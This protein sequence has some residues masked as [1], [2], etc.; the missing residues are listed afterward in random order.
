VAPQADRCLQL[1]LKPIAWK[2]RLWRAFDNSTT[3]M[4]RL[5]TPL[6][7]HGLA[8]KP[9]HAL[10]LPFQAA[11]R[12]MVV[13]L[14]RGAAAPL[15]LAWS[16]G[17]VRLQHDRAFAFLHRFLDDSFGFALATMFR[18]GEAQAD[19]TLALALYEAAADHLLFAVRDYDVGVGASLI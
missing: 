15:P 2:A 12:S 7:L 5:D 9:E 3:L 18:S 6:D 13:Y 17:L 10:L 19:V 1:V 16:M 14:E 11:L 8:G 4:M